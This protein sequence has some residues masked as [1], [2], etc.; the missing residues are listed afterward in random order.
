M[1]AKNKGRKNDQNKLR[2]DLIPPQALE[3]IVKV[4]T[5]GAQKYEAR[6]WENG[7]A[8]SRIYSAMMRHLQAWFAGED[9]DQ[10][11]G[12]HHIS[13]VGWGA[14]ALL[15][16]AKFNPEFDDRPKRKEK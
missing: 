12:Q 5:M 15:H 16:Y 8:W 11:N 6:N 3:E 2:Y 7:I 1:N 4:Y 13:S 9:L 14:L 10:D